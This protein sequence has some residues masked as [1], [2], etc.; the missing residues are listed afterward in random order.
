MGFFGKVL[1]SVGVGGAKVAVKLNPGPVPLGGF[2]R[3]TVS[4]R[5]G[6]LT[7]TCNGVL[8][9]LQRIKVVRVEID[10]K[11]RDQS[12]RDTLQEDNLAPYEQTIE[13]ESDCSYDFSMRIPDEGG[14]ESRISYEIVGEADIPGAIDPSGS[15]KVP[16][17]KAAKLTAESI[18]QLV[19]LAR[20][21]HGQG[22]DKYAEL[23]GVLR[24]IL[25][26][27]ER[28]TEALKLAAQIIGIRS[29]PE[30]TSY[31][32]RYLEIVPSDAEA[33]SD[34]AWNAS[35]RGANDE[36]LRHSAKALELAPS[37][38][39]YWT[40]R[41]SLLATAG[42]HLDAAEAYR[43]SL[44]GDSPSA[45][46]YLDM[47][48]QLQKAG[49]SERAVEALLEGG[50]KGEPYLLAE[51][52]DAL[53][54]LGRTEHEGELIARAKE[55]HPEDPEPW[56]VEAERLLKRND[57]A[58]SL[59]A[60]DRALKQDVRSDWTRSRLL[61]LRGTAFEALSRR[62]DARATYEQALAA[63]KNNAEAKSRLR[64]MV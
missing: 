2:A 44:T 53:S 39:G 58:A 28:H 40:Q 32:S 61:L 47:A 17:T 21:L 11:S 18:P 23:E 50:R 14:E 41:A 36:A 29:A 10:G 56:K 48:E 49:R 9:K 35:S 34:L 33:W 15:A 8:V 64:L 20:A 25:S 26:L 27:D 59:A 63:D 4:V 6:K 57:P 12:E 30:A 60:L 52:L 13:P 37:S 55:A 19:E 7:Q 16:L 31:F 46:A 42:R 38:S 43:Q 45:R 1:A 51:L 3:G 24:Q 54:A 22:S 62:D 5:G